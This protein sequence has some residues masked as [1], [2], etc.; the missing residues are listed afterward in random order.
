[1][2]KLKPHVPWPSTWKAHSWC[3]SS[4]LSHSKAELLHFTASLNNPQLLYAVRIHWATLWCKYDVRCWG[5]KNN[6]TQWLRERNLDNQVVE[7]K[8]WTTGKSDTV[9][10]YREP[11]PTGILKHFPTYERLICMSL[12]ATFLLTFGSCAKLNK[13]VLIQWKRRTKASNGLWR[14]SILNKAISFT[15]KLPLLHSF[16]DYPWPPGDMQGVLH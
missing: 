4:G 11:Y 6:K 15:K 10:N 5:F 7:R 13:I 8:G 3:L 2:K 16:L 9:K 1:M 12:T 14:H